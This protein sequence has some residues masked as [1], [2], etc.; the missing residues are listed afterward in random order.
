[1]PMNGFIDYYE[2]LEVSPRASNEV[3]ERSY[4]VLAKKNHPDLN[5]SSQKAFFNEKMGLI[6]EAFNIL[7]D[8]NSRQNYDIIYWS[9]KAEHN[10]TG[11]NDS[12]SKDNASQTDSTRYASHK[13][14]Q[15]NTREK[16]TERLH[17]S[18]GQT[19]F[20]TIVLMMASIVIFFNLDFE[21]PYE[22]ARFMGVV[23]IGS[24]LGS[25]PAIIGAIKGKILYGICGFFSCF[26]GAY[27]AGMVFSIPICAFFIYLVLKK[28]PAL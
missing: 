4:R 6:N 23:A 18:K 14:N 21:N 5:I 7:S 11:D 24:V 12:R 17:I 16:F 13:K 20:L 19:F 25:I 15:F 3:I 2:I 28:K 8:A 10:S 9:K 1:M 22:V 26:I 27:I